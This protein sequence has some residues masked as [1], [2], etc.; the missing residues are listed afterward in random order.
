MEPNRCAW[1]LG[2]NASYIAY[3]D[4]E[5]GQLHLDKERYLFEMFVLES[6]QAGL[7]WEC[8]LN[9]REAFRKDFK[10][11]D[12]KIVASFDKKK[13]QELLL[14]ENIIRSKGKILAAISNAKIFLSIEKEFGSFKNYLLSFSKG[15]ILFEV[16]KTKNEL[17][18]ALSKDLKKRGVKF[19]G[20]VIAYS[21]LQAIGIINSHEKGCFLSFSKDETKA[22][23]QWD[24]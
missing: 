22:I 23:R 9:K 17:S 21:Y 19:F 6:F 2:H 8:V 7:S 3:H 15:K 12:P 13:V 16:G 24:S 4:K 10:N 14:D 18:D 20:T 11:F 1:C 5:R